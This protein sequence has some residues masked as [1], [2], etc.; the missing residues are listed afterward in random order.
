MA[1]ARSKI[2]WTDSTWS[3]V[4]G[5]A[6]VSAGCTNCYAMRQAHRFSGKGQ[7]YEKLTKMTSHGPVW[8]GAA[9]TVP[10]RLDQPL[11]WRK[12]RRIF[13]N[14]MSDLFH[15]DVADDFID[16]VFAVMAL[17]PRHTFQVLTKRPERMRSYLTSA[18]GNG[19][20]RRDGIVKGRAWSMLGQLPK[21]HHEDLIRRPWP[22]SNV[23]LGISAEDQATADERIPLLL[24]TPA[25]VRFVSLEPLLGE[26]SFVGL[27]ANPNDW[28][29]GTNA[30]EEIDWL[31]C[32]GESGPHARPSHPEWFRSLRDQCQAAG[33]PFFFKQWGQWAQW[34][35]KFPAANVKHI[36]LDGN[37]H[38]SPRLTEPI[39][40]VGKKAAGRI[41][42]GRTWD[43]YP[44]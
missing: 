13:V 6:L 43:E 4:R 40:R 39:V 44:K 11:R 19:T 10:E 24:Q 23:W 37:L 32:G 18:H 20:P 12:P 15:E 2:E 3:P 34:E 14:S 21:Y 30:L 7:P 33:V 28:R 8:T 42:D 35:P 41:L 27:F 9:R 5:C 26:I 31:I 17:T 1:V 16:D 36:D 25:A 22:L 38:D 29:D